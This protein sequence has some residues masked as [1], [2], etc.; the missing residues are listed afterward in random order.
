MKKLCVLL[1]LYSGLAS[2]QVGIGTITPN[3]LLEIESTNQATPSNTDGL[4][5][6][7][8]DEFPVTNPGAGQDGMLVYATG[9]GSVSKGFYYWDNGTTAWVLAT[10]AKNI[11]DLSDGKTDATGSSIFLGTDA[12]ANDDGT[13]NF[14]YSI[15]YQTLNSNTFGWEN[16]A[17]GY[18]SIFSNTGGSLNLGMGTWTLFENTTGAK[19]IAIGHYSLQ[20]NLIGN[21]NVGIGLWS[22][23]SNT[24]GDNNIAMGRNTLRYNTEGELNTGVGATAL[25]NNTI[26]NFNAGFGY[27]SMLGNTTGNNN[28]AFGSKSGKLVQGE[29]NVFLG[30]EAGS[31]SGITPRNLDGSVFIGYQ[32]GYGEVN[33]N[34]LYVENSSSTS[35]LIY[36]E[37]DTDFLGFNADVAIGHQAPLRPLHVINEG[38]SGTQNIVAAIGSNTS[39]RPVLLFSETATA[40]LGDGMSLEYDGRGSG[41]ANRMVFNDIG[42]SPLFEFRNGGDLT[43]VDGDLIVRGTATDREI[44]IEDDAGNADRVLMRQTG[45]QDIFVG[46]IDNN[47]GDTY[48]RA[49]GSTE[50]SVISGTGF[51]GVNTTTPAFTFEVNGN[52]A[53]PGGGSWINSSDRRLKQNINPYTDGLQQLIQIEPVTFNYNAISGFDQSKEHVGVLAQD[54]QKVSPYM[55]QNYHHNDGDYLAVDNSAMTYMLINAVKEQQVEIEALKAAIS[56]LKT[57]LK[58]NE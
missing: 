12:G 14:N 23:F 7:K 58:S 25:H 40:N 4:L 18:Q 9:S 32:A 11:D 50:L 48:V 45:T 56:E 37:F 35:P 49:G 30:Y 2:A 52:A 53:K 47:G 8:V 33:N 55:V 26:G 51:V 44:K 16:I 27:L 36:G 22:L 20:N 39:N 43:L 28:S 13:D 29:N 10:G 21:S 46:D 1:C 3:A 31:R 34:R 42:G 19:N 24:N 5:I 57:L 6:P 41:S 15:G 54:L 38:T 17:I